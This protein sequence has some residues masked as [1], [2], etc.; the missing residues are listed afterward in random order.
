[1]NELFRIDGSDVNYTV[2]PL[3]E[4]QGSSVKWLHHLGLGLLNSVSPRASTIN[5]LVMD[6]ICL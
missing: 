3:E 6:G 5:F 4:L 1:M 2:S